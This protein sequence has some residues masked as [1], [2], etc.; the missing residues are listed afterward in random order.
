[1]K[2]Q[3]KNKQQLSKQKKRDRQRPLPTASH[4]GKP[5]SEKLYHGVFISKKAGYGFVDTGDE[6]VEDILIPAAYC[7]GA[8]DGDQVEVR[9]LPKERE[10]RRRVR[11]GEVIRQRRRGQIVNVTWHANETLLGTVYREGGLW[12]LAPANRNISQQIVIPHRYLNNAQAGDWV[13]CAM[14][15]WPQHHLAA[16]A[17]IEK[18]F[19]P[20]GE[21]DVE[22]RVVAERHGLELDFPDAV[23]KESKAIAERGILPQDYQNRR[24]LRDWRI[25]TIDGDDAKDLDDGVS[26]LQTE[27]GWQLGVHIADV[28]HYVRPGSALD[29]E[30]MRRGTSVYLP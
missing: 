2:Q 22:I 26:I 19:G 20:Q 12:F 1:M 25:V 11:P 28:S 3:K 4:R 10:W 30:A 15:E 29:R 23:C 18:V 21:K 8:M 27:N 5:L 24:D 7:G 14:L 9:L 13:R 17:R 6:G 16:K